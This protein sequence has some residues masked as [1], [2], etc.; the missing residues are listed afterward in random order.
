MK[1]DLILLMFTHLLILELFHGI[2]KKQNFSTLI[3]LNNLEK[4]NL[5]YKSLKEVINASSPSLLVFLLKT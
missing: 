5:F 3:I 2:M 4:N 1:I